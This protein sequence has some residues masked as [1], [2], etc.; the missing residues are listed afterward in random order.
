MKTFT[1]VIFTLSFALTFSSNMGVPSS[2]NEMHKPVEK[3]Q[4]PPT[5]K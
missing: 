5:E 2:V 3:A 4:E 1:S